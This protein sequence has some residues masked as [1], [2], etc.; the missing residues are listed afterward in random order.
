MTALERIYSDSRKAPLRVAFLN[1]PAQD[2]TL[3]LAYV[4]AYIRQEHPE[5]T[6]A[7]FDPSQE[8][9]SAV[10][11]FS[12]HLVLFS[13]VSFDVGRYLQCNKRLKKEL[14]PYIAVFG[15]PHPTYFPDMIQQEGVD[16]IC[17]G[18]GELPMNHLLTALKAGN[19]IASIKGLWVKLDGEVSRN[20]AADL[21]VDLDTL[22]LPDRELIYK[23][24]PVRAKD[25]KKHL[26]GARGCPFICSYCH[27]SS[28]IELHPGGKSWRSR[29]PAKVVEEAEI[30]IKQYHA[31]YLTFNEDIFAGVKIPWLQEFSERYSRLGVPYYANIR[32][33]YVT[34]GLASMLK[35]SGC[36]AVGLAFESGSE[37]YRAKYLFRK[38]SNEK[39]IEATR[40]LRQEGISTV[41]PVMLGLPFTTLE[42]DFNTLDFVCKANPT[43]SNTLIFQP[44]PGLPL[45]RQC[46]EA[47]I[48]EDV[49]PNVVEF[50]NFFKPPDLAGIDYPQ[51]TR[52]ND[53]F[54]LLRFLKQT[55]ALEPRRVFRFLPHGPVTRWLNI[56][57]RYL[58][59][60]H[61]FRFRRTISQ[62]IGEIMT[63]LGSDVY[64]LNRKK[65]TPEW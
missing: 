18:E 54:A 8:P 64:G 20:P 16:I 9:V 5:L 23:K 52:L 14:S 30:L 62:R 38:L 27:N 57:F 60:M 21:I 46:V 34:A 19:D 25:P 3:G 56:F 13:V 45:T 47:G 37:S 15:G 6:L 22:P 58:A 31:G 36:S 51:V 41:S 55:F 12:P 42:D 50:N 61:V 49:S 1:E 53:S 63:A 2:E 65:K 7:F 17:R 10:G 44:Y 29:S 39:L 4:A 43:H 40:L 24:A 11:D 26:M 32:G 33:E 35:K 59:F 28:A 48:L